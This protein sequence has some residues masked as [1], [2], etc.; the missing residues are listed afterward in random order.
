MIN[1]AL[2]SG[3]TQKVFIRF[4]NQCIEIS[5]I[6]VAISTLFQSGYVEI[7]KSDCGN[8]KL[9]DKYLSL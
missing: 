5:I 4:Q 9:I 7:T 1:V 6:C 3:L 2:Y 8:A